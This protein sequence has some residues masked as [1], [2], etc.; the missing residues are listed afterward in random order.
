MTQIPQELSALRHFVSWCCR[1]SS[2]CNILYVSSSR[3]QLFK[4]N[5]AAGLRKILTRELQTVS[6]GLRTNGLHARALSI[7]VSFRLRDGMARRVIQND[8]NLASTLELHLN[9][10]LN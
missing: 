10:N 7:I 3:D 5:T 1:V 8:V 2:L 6:R 4:V 9:L